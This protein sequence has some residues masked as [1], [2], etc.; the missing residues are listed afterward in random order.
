MDPITPLKMH[1]SFFVFKTIRNLLGK[2]AF[3]SSFSPF[4][5]HLITLLAIVLGGTLKDKELTWV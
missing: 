2:V 3:S 1:V 5:K 4:F